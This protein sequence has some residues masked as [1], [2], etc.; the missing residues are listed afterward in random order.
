MEEIIYPQI[1]YLLCKH[2]NSEDFSLLSNAVF[3]SAYYSFAHNQKLREHKDFVG[4]QFSTLP[5]YPL[6]AAKGGKEI[7]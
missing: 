4:S 6:S 2:R 3:S 5:L 1:P 7:L